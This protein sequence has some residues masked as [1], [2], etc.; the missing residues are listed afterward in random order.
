M[1]THI[2]LSVAA[3]FVL[4]A[5]YPLSAF[6]SQ[7]HIRRRITSFCAGIALSYVF[8]HLLPELGNMQT[9]L[10]ES[11]GEERANPW[12]REHLYIMAFIGLL[13]FQIVDTLGRKRTT[14]T[15]RAFGYRSETAF[16]A[17]YTI[18]I[19]YLIMENAEYDRPVILISVALAAHLF[20]TSLDLAERYGKA[21]VRRGSYLLA[22]ATVAG[23]IFAIAGE[24]GERWLMAGLSFLAGGLLINTLKTE[25][26]EPARVRNLYVLLGAVV[27]TTLMLSIYAVARSV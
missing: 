6:V 11:L 24:L 19:G 9:E 23:M 27:Y 4:A 15:Q 3:V 10:L 22:A 13:V 21:F 17:L 26:P 25:L 5:T 18:L 14:N 12:F 16:F 8:L 7:G 20:G 1:N 2:V